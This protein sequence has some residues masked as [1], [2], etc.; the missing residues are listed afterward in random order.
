MPGGE[1]ERASTTEEGLPISPSMGPALAAADLPT[2]TTWPRCWKVPRRRDRLYRE[3]DVCFMR[4]V[5]A[6]RR[7]D[8]FWIGADLAVEI[9]SETNRAHEVQ[10]K[11]AEYAAAGI[12][13]YWI[14]D[15]DRKAM[16]IFTLADRSYVLHRDFL[17]GQGATSVL[18][19]GFTV[20]VSDLFA[21]AEAQA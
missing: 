5:N 14:I 15:P 20:D 17:P 2:R 9:I 13:E 18:L 4:G 6:H 8:R 21:A 11:R 3:P 19:C 16:S 1:V 12:P 10:T 7:T